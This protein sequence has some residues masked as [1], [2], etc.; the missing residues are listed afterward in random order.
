MSDDAAAPLQ[1]LEKDACL[2]ATAGVA[3]DRRAA[4]AVGALNAPRS[5]ARRRPSSPPRTVPRFEVAS[6]K[7]N[8]SGDGRVGMLGEPG[9]RFTATN[10]T[11]VDADSTGYRL[12]GS[13]RGAGR[14]LRLISAR[15]PGCIRPLR[16]RGQGGRHA[17]ANQMSDMIDVPAGRSVQARGAHRDAG[18]SRSMRSSGP[19][20][21]ER[22]GPRFRQSAIDC[23]ALA[24]A[25]GRGPCPKCG[26]STR[27]QAG[28]A[29][30]EARPSAVTRAGDAT[31]RHEDRTGQHDRRR[32]D[33][34]ATRE[35][36]CHRSV[37]RIVLDRTG[38]DRRLRSRPPWIAR[39]L[40]D[41]VAHSAA[42]DRGAG[43]VEPDSTVDLHGRAGT[44]RAELKSTKGPVDDLVIDGRRAADRRSQ[45]VGSLKCQDFGSKIGV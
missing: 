35:L 23:A 6:I 38:L 34:R 33:A 11:P 45:R 15:Q 42:D 41:A 19:G 37:N 10:V 36:R 28:K 4:W 13:C 29:R 16:H 39:P 26:R 32:R 31:V 9:G 2:A 17:P 18:A 1:R 25:R 27:P 30:P 24:A 21:T 8:T 14:Q 7:P 43:A 12:Q 5:A 40:D 44:A 3:V 20:A 22:S